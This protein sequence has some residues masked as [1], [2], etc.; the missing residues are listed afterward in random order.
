MEPSGNLDSHS[1]NKQNNNLLHVSNRIQV[2]KRC[3][4][5]LFLLNLGSYSYLFIYVFY[6]DFN[7]LIFLFY[8]FSFGKVDHIFIWEVLRFSFL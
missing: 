1:P 6:F 7:L 2:V 4:D 5:S 3:L 8:S